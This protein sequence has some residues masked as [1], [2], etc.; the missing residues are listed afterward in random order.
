MKK[1]TKLLISMV[2]LASPAY[3]DLCGDLTQN[4]VQRMTQ[5]QN[6]TNAALSQTTDPAEQT[7]IRQSFQM[8][9]AMLQAEKEAALTSAGCNTPPPPP[10]PTD[11][12]NPPT[13]PT[14]PPTDPTNPPTDPTDPTDPGTTPT[15][16]TDPTD[17]GTPPTDPGTPPTNPGGGTCNPNNCYQELKEYAEQLKAQGVRGRDLMER[18]KC[19]AR[20]LDCNFGS[21]RR[22]EG[23]NHG[24][25]RCR[26]GQERERCGHRKRGHN[27]CDD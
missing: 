15:D 5:L 6:D 9:L 21:W 11:P 24:Y 22:H 25:N 4:Y 16:P 27:R 18:V 13:D 17:P 7:A 20:E 26:H 10:P 1:L 3:A 23:G 8:Q 19:K 14:N 12:T 2:P